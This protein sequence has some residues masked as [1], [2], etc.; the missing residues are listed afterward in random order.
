MESVIEAISTRTLLFLGCSLSV[1]RT[2]EALASIAMRKGHENIPRHYAFLRLK[3][4]GE[5]LDR[6]DL[7]ANSNIFPICFPESYDPDECIEALL[8][9]LEDGVNE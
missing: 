5:R 2:L 3:D 1:D 4:D 9:L 8:W 7:L 6:R